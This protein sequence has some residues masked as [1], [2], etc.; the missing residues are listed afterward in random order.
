MVAIVVSRYLK[1]I[2]L[3][4]VDIEDFLLAQSRLDV[5][6]RFSI[7]EMVRIS[8]LTKGHLIDNLL[9][10]SGYLGFSLHWW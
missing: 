9:V 2:L 4:A 6:R 1:A 7:A 3:V 8:Q 10:L 5:V